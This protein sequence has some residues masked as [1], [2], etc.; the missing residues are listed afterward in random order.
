M[1]QQYNNVGQQGL[2][3]YNGGGGAAYGA[4]AAPPYGRPQAYGQQPAAPKYRLPPSSHGSQRSHVRAAS[5]ALG[6]APAQPQAASLAYQAG[7]YQ[8]RAQARPVAQGYQQAN[9]GQPGKYSVNNLKLP[10]LGPQAH[11]GA[12]ARRGGDYRGNAGAEYRHLPPLME[13]N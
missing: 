3:N 13:R 2:D 4:Y 6:V 7:S 5:N 9:A 12:D 10:S 8:Q 1:Q 11:Q